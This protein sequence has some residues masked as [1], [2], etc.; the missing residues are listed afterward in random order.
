MFAFVKIDREIILEK[1]SNDNLYKKYGFFCKKCLTRF[2]R[3]D[4]V[5]KLSQR[6]DSETT[7]IT[8]Q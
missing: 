7:L 8:K 2:E 1:V 4:K 6:D 3:Y 5:N